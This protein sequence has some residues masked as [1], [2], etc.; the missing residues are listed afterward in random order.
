VV[1]TFGSC[2]L[3]R[4]WER[5]LRSIIPLTSASGFV[6][7]YVTRHVAGSFR[8]GTSQSKHAA[9]AR[10]LGRPHDRAAPVR[11]VRSVGSRCVAHHMDVEDLR[12]RAAH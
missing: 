8:I 11:C 9:D 12:V 4:L 1:L 5:D 10:L 6:A 3:R 2:D 7:L